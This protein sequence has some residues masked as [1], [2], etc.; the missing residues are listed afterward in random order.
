MIAKTKRAKEIKKK[1]E[2]VTPPKPDAITELPS[3]QP[4][5]VA[6]CVA[7]GLKNSGSRVQFP[8]KDP[9]NIGEVNIAHA[10]RPPRDYD[11]S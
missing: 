8:A 9:S 6:R 11:V 1:N 4:A 3:K 2:T 10:R 7:V 5:S